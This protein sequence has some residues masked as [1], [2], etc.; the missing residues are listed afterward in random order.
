MKGF[1]NMKISAKL[2]SGFIVVALIAGAVGGFGML[3]L[4]SL[5]QSDTELYQYMTVPVSQI[6]N[7]SI[8]FQKLRVHVRDLLLAS[9]P[10][11]KDKAGAQIVERHAEMN[12][13]AAEFEKSIRDDAQMRA[14]YDTYAADQENLFK[15]LDKVLVLAKAGQNAEVVAIMSATGESGIASAA[16]QADIDNLVSMKVE[17]AKQVAAANSAQASKAMTTM[18]ALV[19]VAMVLA[20]VLGLF[21]SN[22]ISRPLKKA[23]E[24]MMEMSKGHLSM[25][26]NLDTEDE[27]GKMAA[28]MDYFADDLKN[29]MIGVLNS[30]AGGEVNIIVTAKDDK[31]EIAPAMIK[32]IETIQA[33]LKETNTL[34]TA[35]VEGKLSVRANASGFVGE[36][37]QLINGINRILEAV[38]EPIQEAAL[39]LTEMS[40]GNLQKRVIGQ[41]KGDHADIKNALN[42]TLDS[43]SSYVEEIAHVLNEMAA[44]N[45]DIGITSDYKGDFTAIKDALNLIISSLNEVLGEIGSA[46]D[47]VAAGSRQVSDGSQALSQGSTEQASAVEQLTASITEIAAQTKQNAVNASQANELANQARTNADQ[48]NQYMQGMLKSMRDINESSGNISRIIKVIDEIAFQTNILALNAAVEAARAGQHGK[49]FAVVAEEVRNLAARSANAA[50][51]TTVMIEGSIVKVEDGTRIANETAGALTK[52]VEGVAKAADL[53]GEIAVASNEQANGIFQINKGV[54]QVSQVVQTNS[55]TAQQSAA[56]SEELN[57]QAEMLKDM[58][59]NFRLKRSHDAARTAKSLRRDSEAPLQP[60]VQAKRSKKNGH[61]TSNVDMGIPVISLSDT[62]YGKY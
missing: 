20:I 50:K 44:S 38:V 32:T 57:G 45:L 18:A 14:A 48:G 30:I 39:V 35:A 29:N 3:N 11:A 56:A 27:V 23:M 46:S 52:I 58:V 2:L 17:Q 4:K 5:N 40:N 8:A 25:R 19:A 28:A 37:A 51:E 34:I 15:I 22:S 61:T 10:E 16:L 7:V 12:Q 49:G 31:D 60:A 21:L 6:S 53:V 42:N 36:W 24:M 33:L 13:L 59:S 47:Q 43:L 26:M 62:E 55:A 9:T 1:Y 54:E 41:Y